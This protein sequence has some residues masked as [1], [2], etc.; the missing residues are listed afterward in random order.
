ME[1][2]DDA[3]LY[4]EDSSEP[5]GKVVDATRKGEAEGQLSTT[6]A[7]K[8]EEV[9]KEEQ[10]GNDEEEDDEDE[11]DDDDSDSV[12]MQSMLHCN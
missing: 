12:S 5:Q 3:F 1:E 10:E 7:E 2:D 4:G 6:E 9:P 11:D 8:G